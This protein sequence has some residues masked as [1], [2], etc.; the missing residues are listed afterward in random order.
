MSAMIGSFEVEMAVAR[1]CVPQ[2]PASP[3]RDLMF[4]PPADWM[5]AVF[6]AEVP[7]TG[8]IRTGN[9]L[10]PPAAEVSYTASVSWNVTGPA[11]PRW[12]RSATASVRLTYGC[13]EPT[14]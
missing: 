6:T 8:P 11:T 7:G 13:P 9:W 14:L 12:F 4:A 3:P 1:T 2:L 10:P 5:V